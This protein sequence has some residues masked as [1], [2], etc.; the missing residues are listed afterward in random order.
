MAAQTR[1]DASDR[2]L[3]RKARERFELVKRLEA[4]YLRSLRQLT[5]QVDHIVKGMA[6]N[7]VVRNSIELQNT[8]RRYSQTIEPW[9]RSIAEKMVLRVARKDE[10]AWMA[11][12]RTMGK[13]LRKELDE[14]PTGHAL[15]AFLNEQVTLIT[16]LPLEAAQ[17]VHKLTLEGI[18][19]GRR[20]KEIAKDILDTGKVTESR[21]KLIARTE[22]ART[23][24]GLTMARA[25]FVGS[26]HYIWR[27]SGDVDVRKS[28]KEM[29]GQ[30][31]P[32]N[33]APTLSDG[34]KT[35]AGMIYN[36]RC[37]AEPILTEE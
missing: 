17:R 30:V 2:E 5:R 25:Q 15:Q 3:R 9:A 34:S 28:H 19:E 36:C 33:E 24:A 13:S 35:H 20:A 10:A 7:G 27:T 21:A 18:T 22:I 16:S 29:N 8:L 37:F 11:L 31:I 6:P 26:T 12:G 4:E 14:A 1:D 23:A 32:W